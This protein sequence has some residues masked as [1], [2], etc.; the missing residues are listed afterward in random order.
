MWA[1]ASFAA[2]LVDPAVGPAERRRHLARLLLPGI[3][4]GALLAAIALGY[5]A[6][7][8]ATLAAAALAIAVGRRLLERPGLKPTAS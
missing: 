3:V 7:R 4:F 8:P 2:G 1:Q 5:D 6:I